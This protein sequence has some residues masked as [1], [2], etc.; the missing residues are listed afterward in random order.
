MTR[1]SKPRLWARICKTSSLYRDVGLGADL[2][3]TDQRFL[4]TVCHPS[5]SVPFLGRVVAPGTN[6]GAVGLY[7]RPPLEADLPL[8]LR[9]REAAPDTG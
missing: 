9:S 5:E 6:L 8:S 3:L 7:P 1:L 4:E 2:P